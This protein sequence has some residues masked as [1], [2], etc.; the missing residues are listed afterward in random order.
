ML[1]NLLISDAFAQGAEAATNE[2][3]FSSFVPLIAI[4]VIF[5]FLIIRPQ[6]KKYKEHQQMV[7][8]LK[9]GDKVVTSGGIVATVKKVL[10]DDNQ[11]EV[12]IAENVTV[13]V[14]RNHVSEVVT[15]KKDKK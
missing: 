5:Y 10:E 2:M 6:S 1:N 8:N 3:S 15:T 12:E 9:A 13:K 11:L 7:N 4:F 14:V